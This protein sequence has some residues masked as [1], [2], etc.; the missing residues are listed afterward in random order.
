MI[1][2]PP[3][4]VIMGSVDHG[5]TTLLDYI[6]KSSVA[7]KEAGGI[8]QSVGAYEIRHLPQNGA[9]INAED[10]GKI[11][12]ESAFSQRSSAEGDFT[13]GGRKITF[14]DTPGH[15]AFSKMKARGAKIAD[16]AVLVVASDDGV[17]PQTKE[18]IKI[19]QAAKI[20]FIVAINKIDKVPDTD[21]TKNELMQAGVLLEGYGG[22]ISN[23][24][25]SAKT[26]QGVDDLLDLILLT[27]EV[28][29]LTCD[30]KANGQGF[31]LE[32]KMDSRRGAVATAIIK[33][34][35]VKQ[36][37]YIKAH[38]AFGKI[39]ILENFLGKPIKEASP[40]SPVRILGFETL[41]KAGEEFLAGPDVKP[42]TANP[43]AVSLSNTPMVKPAVAKPSLVKTAAEKEGTVRLI[44]K[45]D[46]TGS[47]EALTELIKN[48][49]KKKEQ[50]IEIIDEGIGEITDGDV[51]AAISTKSIII[52]FRTN[53]NKAAESLARAQNIK[54]VQSEIIYELLK[55]IEE[56]LASLDKK[57]AKGKLEI[58]AIFS[59]KGTKQL[60]GGR[61]T[62]GVISNNAVLEI[63][64]KNETI[65]NG[66]I[67]NLQQAKNDTKSV[68]TGNEC[69][70]LFTS[71]VEIKVGDI[72]ISR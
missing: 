25:I 28:E 71:Q 53:V 29:N 55:T 27:A 38:D 64:R 49:P 32:A 36:G 59:K 12:R 51:N 4:V 15:E 10:R 6:R 60:I 68:P 63:E 46:V 57:I 11:Q 37:D 23:Q 2:R 43:P 7:A 40:S 67:V 17:Q 20:P 16:I 30:P 1:Q 18:A 54:I 14:I 19:I 45:A 13:I 72:L 9:E 26:G 5:K 39:K 62:E 31:I 50:T 69:G 42:N 3:I 22:N 8:T 44:L 58:L 70:L 35:I 61:V 21:R 34:G 24:P 52:G 65:G 33:N 48:L 66:K 41:P 56:S 47:L